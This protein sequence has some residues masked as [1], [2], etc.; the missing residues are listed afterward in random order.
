[1][2]A[3]AA[4]LGSVILGELAEVLPMPK[5][6]MLG[7]DVHGLEGFVTEGVEAAEVEEEVEMG[8][9]TGGHFVAAVT[10]AVLT[11]DPLAVEELLLEVL[12]SLF[13]GDTGSIGRET[14][15]GRLLPAMWITCWRSWIFTS[16]SVAC[17]FT[18]NPP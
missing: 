16:D 3:E 6:D 1:M 13:P 2:T 18:G 14:D 15:V 12:D 17:F 8:C 7:M 10:V 5:R 9:C 4:L 11:V